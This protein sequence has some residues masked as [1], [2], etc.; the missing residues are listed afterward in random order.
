MATTDTLALANTPELQNLS[1]APVSTCEGIA[2]L[3]RRALGTM[4][5][6]C[7]SAQ[8]DELCG[9]ACGERSDERENS[10]NG[11]RH[12][13]PDTTAGTIDL[14]IPKLRHGSYRPDDVI[15]PY[16][17]SDRAVQATVMETCVNGVSTRKAERVARQLGIDSM[18]R[19][20]VS[21]LTADL[22]EEVAQP[23]EE[24]LRG[25]LFRYVWLDATLAGCRVEHRIASRAIAGAIGLDEAGCKRV[26][27]L[28]V[29]DTESHE[30]RRRLP[31][32]PRARGLAGVRLAVSDDHGGLARAV[33]EAL[34]GASWQ[35]RV[36]HFARNAFEAEASEPGRETVRQCLKAVWGQKDALSTRACFHAAIDLLGEEGCKKAAKLM[37]DAEQDVLAYLQLTPRHWVRIRSDNVQ[38]RTNREIKRRVKVVGAF[39]SPESALRLVGSVLV[40]E[41]IAWSQRRVFGPASLEEGD[42]FVEPEHSAAEVEEARENA[43]KIIK[44][45]I[46]KAKEMKYAS[47]PA[48]L[49]R[50]PSDHTSGT[51]GRRRSGDDP[52]T[53][54]FGTRPLQCASERR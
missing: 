45:A 14:A 21:R 31:G 53:P 39:P 16:R 36:T 20:Q 30:D 6:A 41:N 15:E 27:G 50:T 4:A 33:R 22:D 52:L 8:A 26:I 29:V 18:S 54:P 2:E 47:L 5:D 7:M 17:R 43:V 48:R 44:D 25:H 12:R 10:R 28:D 49:A 19:S 3:A 13:T 40:E 51:G 23:R 1:A 37:E 35:R 38:E 11:Y 24:S 32:G 46:A 42:G 34:Q 9:A